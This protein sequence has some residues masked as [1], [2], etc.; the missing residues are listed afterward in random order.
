MGSKF[1]FGVSLLLVFIISL[2]FLEFAFDGN[3][4][5]IE[6]IKKDMV[7]SKNSTAN[8]LVEAKLFDVGTQAPLP[9]IKIISL[10]KYEVLKVLEGECRQSSILVGHKKPN[11]GSG[12]I[13]GSVYRLSLNKRFPEDCHII[14]AFE[15]EIESLDGYYCIDFELINN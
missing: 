11:Y 2:F 4:E 6:N 8:L 3:C 1:F 14:N 15:Q 10:M 12:F 13:P 9:G 5:L 7:N